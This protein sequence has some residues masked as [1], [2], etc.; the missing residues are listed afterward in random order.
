MSGLDEVCQCK[1][2]AAL[3]PTL[4]ISTPRTKLLADGSNKR[5]P[6]PST[7]ST[8]ELT[9]WITVT[10]E[11]CERQGRGEWVEEIQH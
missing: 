8:T 4:H 5:V 3:Q 1:I 2:M 11:A 7:L 10:M 6:S 9:W